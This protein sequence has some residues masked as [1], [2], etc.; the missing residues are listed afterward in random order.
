MPIQL[1]FID[2]SVQELCERSRSAD[3]ALGTETARRLRARLADLQAAANI[4]ELPAG[5]PTPDSIHPDRVAIKLAPNRS[6]VL[7]PA[8][9]PVPRDEDGAVQWLKVTKVRVTGPGDHH[10]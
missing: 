8:S 2:R 5:R 1:T 3:A 4:T 6:L 10:E 9:N 7:E